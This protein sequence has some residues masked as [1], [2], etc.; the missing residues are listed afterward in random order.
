MSQS[1][2]TQLHN[3][4][5]NIKDFETDD[6]VQ[7]SNS[8]LILQSIYINFREGQSSCTHRPQSIVYKIDYFVL[9]I[10]SSS[11]VLLNIRVYLLS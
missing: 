1:Q 5:K 8:I 11:L 9:G 3:I 7:Y 2:V 10:L 4:E 6:I